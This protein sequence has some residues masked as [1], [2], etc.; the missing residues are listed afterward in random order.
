MKKSML[1]TAIP[2]ALAILALSGCGKCQTAW[3][4]TE[5]G[6]INLSQAPFIMANGAMSLEAPKM[7]V[8]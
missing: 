8:S 4:Q 5:K 2:A 1:K 6:Y 3:Y 7:P